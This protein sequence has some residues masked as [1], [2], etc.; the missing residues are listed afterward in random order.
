MKLQFTGEVTLSL[1]VS[2]LEK[3]EQWYRTV[4]GFSTQLKLED[5]AWC[6]MKRNDLATR[7]GLAEV[8]D[9]SNGNAALMRT[10]TDLDA[11]RDYL[12][13]AAVEVSDIIEVTFGILIFQINRG[14][15]DLVS[16]CKN[17]KNS[18]NAACGPK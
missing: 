6:E 7:I 18:F 1:P 14:R 3:S 8:Q 10:V 12:R 15:C 5:P 4:L 9:V 11:A 17:R 2:R 16:N 13:R